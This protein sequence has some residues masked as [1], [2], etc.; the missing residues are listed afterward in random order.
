M[1]QRCDP[2]GHC[3]ISLSLWRGLYCCSA[4]KPV[5]KHKHWRNGCPTYTIA[6]RK[7]CSLFVIPSLFTP[8]SKSCMSG[9][10]AACTSW[11]S[12]WPKHGF[13][14]ET[15]C[16]LS[17]KS[18]SFRKVTQVALM[19]VLTTL[20]FEDFPW[21]NRWSLSQ[22]HEAKITTLSTVSQEH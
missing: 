17:F 20:H 14:A 15:K 6:L 19:L 13:P 12:L 21:V 8:Y 2:E 9:Q 1:S 5:C 22:V 16:F 18:P 3:F 10:K 7:S 11:P 4:D